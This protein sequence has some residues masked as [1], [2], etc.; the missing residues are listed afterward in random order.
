MKFLFALLLCGTLA[1]SAFGQENCYDKLL[2]KGIEQFNQGNYAE[3]KRKWEA[4]L[5]RED[6]CPNLS[7][8]QRQNL[9]DW[10]AKAR[11]A[12]NPVV[13]TPQLTGITEPETVLV[14]GGT[15]QMGD[16]FG[17]PE[18]GS[19]E[20]VH[21]VKLNS[22]RM[23]KYELSVAEFKAF[24]DD[25]N[26]QTD[27]DKEGDSYVLN[28]TGTSWET[29]TGVNWRCDVK[30]TI[31]PAYEY[32]HPVIHV[33]WNDATEY[34]KWLS[35]ETSKIYRLPTEAEWEF[36]ARERGKKVRFGNGKDIINPS[37]INFDGSASLKLKY[38][39]AGEYR[40]KTVAVNSFAPNALGLYNMSGNVG[41]WCAD[42]YGSSYDSGTVSTP[43]SNPTGAVMGSGRV[44]RGGS[45][46]YYP[47]YCRASNRS[48]S[49]PTSR[50]GNFGFRL[51][52]SFQ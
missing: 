26:Y 50:Y 18:A 47:R 43:V 45:W 48:Y 8:A 28:A 51:A 4:A 20:T 15:F 41:E 13:V 17:D 23:G 9:N 37:E 25:T 44:I 22:F 1:V 38:S 10:L 39:V 52:L 29:K 7:S 31:R 16:N 33:S 46:D 42:W 40:Q 12:E 49:T 34:C 5:D 24:I 27:A 21:Y 14:Q 30:G 3:A 19:D 35:R 36:A 32:N 2:R 11:L 6:G